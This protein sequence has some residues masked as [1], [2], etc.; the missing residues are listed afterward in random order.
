MTALNLLKKKEIKR[1]ATIIFP[2]GMASPG[3][4]YYDSEIGRWLSVDPMAAARPG[5]SPYN[6]CQNNPLGRIDPDGMLDGPADDNGGDDDKPKEEKDNLVIIGFSL[7]G[8]YY[9]VGANVEAGIAISTKTGDAQFFFKAGGSMGVGASA[10]LEM[11]DQWNT[12]FEEFK[13]NNGF[14]REA[15][16]NLVEIEA[17]FGKGGINLAL[18]PTNNLSLKEAGA[19]IGPGAGL[20]INFTN[21]LI[22]STQFNVITTMKTVSEN[23]KSAFWKR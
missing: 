19:N 10:G 7:A 15:A 18:D 2:E 12:S 21:Y 16:Q 17:G 4:R 11:T 13:S 3:A 6:Y 14:D 23:H 1:A 5:L 9:V 22:T 8:A 20:L